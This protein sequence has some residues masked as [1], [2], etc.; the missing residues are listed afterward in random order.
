MR[1]TVG[2]IREKNGRNSLGED[3][4]DGEDIKREHEHDFAA[5]QKIS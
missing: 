4:M 3:S 2:Y 1:W 5:V